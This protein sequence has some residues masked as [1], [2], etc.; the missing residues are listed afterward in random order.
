[1]DRIFASFIR[2]SFHSFSAFDNRNAESTGRYWLKK[3]F[4]VLKNIQ[5]NILLKG[6][7]YIDECFFSV[8]NKDI[9]KKDGKKLRGISQNKICVA[10]GVDSSHSFFLVTGVSKL[11]EKACL[12]TYGE[13]IKK[14][15]EN[16]SR[17][18]KVHR[19]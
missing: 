16:N 9:K 1:M 5:D 15:F 2:V 4:L 6:T 17:F 3:I 13:H 11:S 18:R 19:F 12:N 7:V 8:I 14:S 10:T